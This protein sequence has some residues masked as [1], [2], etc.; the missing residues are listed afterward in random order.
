MDVE[1]P[2][3]QPCPHDL[4]VRVEAVA[5][6]PVD[7]TVRRNSDPGG[8][9]KVLG[10]D[11]AG[12]VVAV[13]DRAELF[14]VGDEVFYAGAIDR[15]GAN[16]QYHVVDES[17]VGRKPEQL[18]QYSAW[19]LCTPA[20]TTRCRCRRRQRRGGGPPGA[21]LGEVVGCGRHV[22]TD[23]TALLRVSRLP[24]SR[25]TVPPAGRSTRRSGSGR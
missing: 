1:L 14:A 24:Y 18:R 8:R 10:W 19:A 2:V 5:V 25:P 20:F 22:R 12:T 11:A 9:L 7:Y 15:P 13:G 3:P 23:S 21:R 17:I 4:L 16:A 6:N